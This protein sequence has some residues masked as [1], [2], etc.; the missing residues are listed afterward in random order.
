MVGLRQVNDRHRRPP[1]CPGMPNGAAMDRQASLDRYLALTA[2]CRRCHRTL[3]L[4]NCRDCPMTEQR[5]LA[6]RGA[7]WTDRPVRGQAASGSAVPRRPPVL[8]Q[9]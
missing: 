4:G 8:P 2:V 1:Y 7:A 6:R 3:R 9:P 5:R